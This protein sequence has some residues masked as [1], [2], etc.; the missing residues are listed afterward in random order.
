MK[1]KIIQKPK[2]NFY[3]GLP[4]EESERILQYKQK[5]IEHALKNNEIQD[6]SEFLDR[7]EYHITVINPKELKTIAKEDPEFPFKKF[8]VY[9]GNLQFMGL[10]RA[11]I[12]DKI[13][14]FIV[15]NW[16]KRVKQTK[17]LSGDEF[18][19]S[20]NMEKY[21]FHITLGFIKSDIFNVD[22]GINSIIYFNN[23]I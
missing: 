20:F 18:R 8:R 9:T 14:Y 12:E 6:K 15:I 4:F 19:E 5:A 10:G 21:D 22:K 13:A 2:D 23:E 11:Q 1:T 7:G 17:T 3:I 16:P